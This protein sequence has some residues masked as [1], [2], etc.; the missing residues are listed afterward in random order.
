MA[1]S[2]QEILEILVKNDKLPKD[3]ADQIK[4]E[5]INTDTSIETLL[6]KRHLISEKDFAQARAETLKIPFV[7][8]SK[9]TQSPVIRVCI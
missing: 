2:A 9:N 1:S 4:V 3:V 8:L 5:S 7:D 6:L